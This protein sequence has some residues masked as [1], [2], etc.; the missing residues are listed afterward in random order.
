LI[1][2][3]EIRNAIPA[4]DDQPLVLLIEDNFELRRFIHSVL[5]D[6]YQV[7]E[8]ANGEEGLALGLERI[9][10]LVITDLMMPL[11]NGYQVCSGLKTNEKTSHIP[12]MM[13]TAKADTDSRIAGLE[14]RA[15][16]YLSKPFDQRELLAT[17]ENLIELRRRLQDKYKQANIWLADNNSIPSMEQ[18]FLDKIKR[19]VEEHLD[20]EQYGVDQLGDEIGLSRTQLHRK[21]KGLTGQGPGE[22][23][24]SVRL[25]RAYELLKQKA[26]TIAEVGYMVGFGNPNN[27]S[28]SFSKYFGFAP[29]EAEKH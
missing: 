26:G 16:A 10:D 27:F 19:S 24:R 18:V 7:L 29:S 17:I 21:L 13:L 9:P 6:S 3:D 23:I 5:A 1:P 8:S 20:D 28:T 15:D 14:T 22:L 12:V 25:Q 4:N 11:M 2:E